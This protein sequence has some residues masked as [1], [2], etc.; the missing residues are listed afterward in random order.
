MSVTP[1]AVVQDE[2]TI[3]LPATVVYETDPIKINAHKDNQPE[4]STQ[5]ESKVPA[6]A[7]TQA[8]SDQ[9]SDWLSSILLFN[10]EEPAE[11][12]GLRKRVEEEEIK[13]YMTNFQKVSFIVHS[14][15]SNKD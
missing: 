2:P 12:A 6:P 8:H 14:Q 7:D 3:D 15:V 13:R 5:D 11:V 1:S 4:S 10:R 9:Q